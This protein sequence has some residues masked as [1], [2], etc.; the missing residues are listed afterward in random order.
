MEIMKGLG[1]VPTSVYSVLLLLSSILI[2]CSK[3]SKTGDRKGLGM[4]LPPVEHFP[5][6][7]YKIS[8]ML[9]P[10]PHQIQPHIEEY[11]LHLRN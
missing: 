3:Q 5:A 10:I 8:F 6:G 4:R 9:D 11:K 7:R 2:P 1:R